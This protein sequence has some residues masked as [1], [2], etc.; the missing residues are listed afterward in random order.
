M[1]ERIRICVAACFYYTGLVRLALWFMRRSGR[2][3]IILNYHR[4]NAQ[5]LRGQMLYLR[6][7]YR[8]L[9]LEDALQEFYAPRNEVKPAKDRRIPL[10]LTFDDGYRDN[11][12]FG[13]PLARELQVPIT[14]F[15][16]PGYID[17][18]KCF[19]WLEGKRLAD[20][21]QVDD[22]TIEGKVFHLESPEEREAL[23]R[24]IDARLRCASTVV[25]REAF[26]A[27]ICRALSVTVE[28]EAA[29]P[30]TWAQVREMQES[31]W[32]SFGAHTMHHPV[33]SSLSEPGEV[34]YEVGECRKALEE[35]LG[36]AVRTFAYPIGKLEHI[37][38][39]ALRAVKT[40]GYRW[41][42]TTMEEKNTPLTDPYTL[43]RL[44]GVINKHWLV[45]ASE[46]VGLLGVLSRLRNRVH[47]SRTRT[48]GASGD[49]Q[50]ATTRSHSRSPLDA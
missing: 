44:P 43:R 40:A 21:T 27:E 16:I 9:H 35:R 22:V 38:D 12:L 46:L 20:Q 30:V 45:M 47:G 36:H 15:L 10:V 49:A 32:V 50:S 29:M 8:V 11:Y 19:W 17:S 13:F 25:E 34:Q 5:Q 39:E 42:V 1:R 26:L 7:H 48:R 41:A 4:A 6:R 28:E 14:I 3:L 2:H 24:A 23:A 31:G 37:G 18:G 33:L